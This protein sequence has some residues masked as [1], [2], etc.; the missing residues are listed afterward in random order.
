M[1]K[2]EIEKAKLGLK[3]VEDFVLQFGNDVYTRILMEEILEGV[4]NA[5]TLFVFG[6]QEQEGDQNDNGV[7]DRQSDVGEQQNRRPEISESASAIPEKDRED[8]L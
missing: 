3:T 1:D 2:R 6:E 5:E 7:A 8:Y 4:M